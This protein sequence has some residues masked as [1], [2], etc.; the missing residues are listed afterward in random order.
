MRIRVSEEIR[1]QIETDIAQGR[2][3]PG[4][5]LDEP[6]LSR[7][8]GVSRTPAREAL[9][10]LAA[11]GLIQFRSRNGAEVAGLGPQEA[12]ERVEVL[13]ALEGE[14]AGLAAR[15]MTEAERLALQELHLRA[16]T[17]VR[18]GDNAAYIRDNADFHAAIYSG[19]RNG[20]L[21]REITARLRTRLFRQQ[22]L[23][24][25]AQ[26]H[27]SWEEHAAIVEAILA[28]DDAAARQAM[29]TH[30]NS[31][32]TIFADLMASSIVDL[33]ARP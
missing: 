15:R 31:G 1:R 18:A 26:L 8:F 25:R 9:F 23:A 4:A 12:I 2:L 28:G 29:R 7:R 24:R 14:A 3:L 20:Y 27:A 16:E 32:G 6:Y 10:A 33:P 13:T 11:D 30:I 19:A 5:K 17:S 22:A 21:A